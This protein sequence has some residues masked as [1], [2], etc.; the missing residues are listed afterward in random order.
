MPD[1][2]PGSSLQMEA[3]PLCRCS[4]IGVRLSAGELPFA[5]SATAS[6][7]LTGAGDVN[8]AAVRRVTTMVRIDG[9]R[10]S[11]SGTIVRQTVALSALTG[12]SVHITNIR[13]RRPHPGLRPQHA[14]AVEAIA[15]AVGAPI[16]GNTGGSGQLP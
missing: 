2:P 5:V 15:R 13:F 6:G 14:R 11:G 4:M 12:R 7:K 9:S 1:Q 3:P 16:D 8:L 10:F